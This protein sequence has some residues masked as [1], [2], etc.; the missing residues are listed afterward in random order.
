[1]K[2]TRILSLLL[3]LSIFCTLIVP[4]TRAYAESDP[5]NGM[6][7]SKTAT[8]N[9]DGS[10]TITLEAFATGSK[11]TTVQEKD[12]P[13]DIILV[14]D[15]SGAM[16]HD[17]GQVQYT[18]Y[19]GDNTQNKS[20]YEKRHNGGSEN[21]WYKLNNNEYIAVSV[22]QEMESPAISG[23]NNRKYYDNQNS[24]YCLVSGEYKSVTVKRE[25]QLLYADEYWY[26][27]DTTF[28]HQD[29]TTA[30]GWE[31]PATPGDPA[32]LIHINTCTLNITKQNGAND[33][34]YV[35]DVYKDGVKYSEVTVWG[36]GTETIV[37]LPVGTY[38]I[39]E[40]TGW[41]WRYTPVYSGGVTLGEDNPEG[42]IT[43]TNSIQNNYW[44]NGF[45]EVVRNI[46]KK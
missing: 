22:E 5:D 17:I 44:L 26:T 27:V 28:V 35:F 7:I 3:C 2:K 30:C 18:A 31:A 4:G 29:C 36:N 12:I 14:L 11:T 45:S 25:G 41:S 33:E 21:L 39:E 13:T 15:Q 10:Y 37:E 8:A 6:K 34:S 46:I 19:T 1:M 32:F 38:T 40:G 24:L 20:N 42:I 16:A 23:W 9:K 43:C